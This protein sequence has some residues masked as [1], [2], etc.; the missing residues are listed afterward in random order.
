MVKKNKTFKKVSIYSSIS[1][2]EILQI[3]DH[4]QEVIESFDLELLMPKSSTTSTLTKGR[5]YS[6]KY[7]QDN[8]NLILAI[9]GDGTL[10]SCARKFGS[11]GIPVAGVNLGNLGFLTDIAPKELTSS[12]KQ[13][14]NGQFTCEE[15]IFLEASINNEKADLALNEIVIHSKEV[16][17]LI[18]YE[19]HIDGNFVFRQRADGILVSSPTGSTAYSLSA[20]G[21]LI[22][23]EVKA[24]SIIPMYA[25]SLNAR[26]LIVKEDSEIQ[27]KICRKGTSKLS[28]DSHKIHQLKTNDL[29][30][31]SR[32]NSR[33]LL[34]H[35][36]N[37]DFYSACR[38]KLG[39]SLGMKTK[40]DRI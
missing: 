31:I 22:H 15:R 6:D 2:N 7:I 37:H 18:E 13:V 38:T 3:S 12:L 20:D 27:I 8:S 40:I 10:L 19:L 17:Q 35:P 34:I 14:L 25:H 39:W 4:I 30:R 36:L 1:S 33:L 32:S 28:L 21:P 11:K 26:P 16:A 29:V 23:P 24:I 5:T 9:G